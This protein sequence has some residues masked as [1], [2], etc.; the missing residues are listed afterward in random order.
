MADTKTLSRCSAVVGVHEKE[1][2]AGFP[3]LCGALASAPHPDPDKGYREPLC[4][5]HHEEAQRA[6]G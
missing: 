4:G 2:W 3:L 6:R 5:I 1:P